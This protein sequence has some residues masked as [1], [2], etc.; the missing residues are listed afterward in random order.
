MLVLT[1]L[2]FAL[3][4]HHLFVWTAIGISSV[5]AILVGTTRN[6]PRRRAPWFLLAAAVACLVAGDIAAELLI[7]VFHQ[8]D[9]F[10]SIADVFYLTMYVLIAVGMIWLYRTGT[11]RP[12]ASWRR[13]GRRC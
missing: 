7:R 8:P 11:V 2:N 10:P 1:V 3:P 9:P 13:G 6:A 5:T 4:N 12:S